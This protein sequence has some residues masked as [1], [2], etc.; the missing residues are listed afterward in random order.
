MDIL[1]FISKFEYHCLQKCHCLKLWLVDETLTF[2]S[3]KLFFWLEWCRRGN[4][5]YIDWKWMIRIY[6]DVVR[7]VFVYM[8][9]LSKFAIY[10]KICIFYCMRIFAECKIFFV[11]YIGRVCYYIAS[12]SKS[13]V[14]LYR[15]YRYMACNIIISH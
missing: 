6:G 13:R 7:Y 1:Y 11:I 14:S 2:Y 4:S 10:I 3:K 5:T 8:S 9:I 15:V 12:S